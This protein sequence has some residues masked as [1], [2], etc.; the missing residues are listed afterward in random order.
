[1][2]KPVDLPI[3]FSEEE[4]SN[5]SA[6]PSFETILSARLSRRGVLRGGVGT[7]GLRR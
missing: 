6:N 4:D 7:A 2:N 1:M 3:G 5:T